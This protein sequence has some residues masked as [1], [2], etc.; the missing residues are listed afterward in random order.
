MP[1]P[2]P[3]ET[4]TDFMDRCVPMVMD[5]GS[6]DSEDQAVAM[7]SS[8]WEQDKAMTGRA[9]SILHIKS[10]NDEQRIIEGIASTPTPDRIGDIVDPLGA[11]FSLPMP[12]LWQHRSDQPIGQVTWAKAAA[13][14]I[15][16]KAKIAR[17]DEPGTLKDRLDE[18]WQSIK[19]G[20]V[21]AVS[22]GF[23][24]TKFD[25]IKGGGIEFKEWEWLELSAVTIPAN[26]DATIS[27][28]RSIDALLRQDFKGKPAA[29][30]TTLSDGNKQ[31]GGTAGQTKTVMAKEA[32]PMAKKTI[33]EQISA[34]EATRV[35]KAARMADIMETAGEKGETLGEP[36]REEYD[37]LKADVKSVD[38]HLVR[39]REMESI[40]KAAAKPVEGSSPTNALVTRGSGIISVKPNRPPGIG[41]ARAIIARMVAL[42]TQR[43]P[44][45]VAQERWPSD[46]EISDFLK[47]AVT[48]METVTNATE[49]NV[50]QNMPS[51]FVEYLRPMTLLGR[52]PGFRRVPFNITIPRQTGGVT[53]HWVAEGGAKPVGRPDFDSIT[54]RWNKCA[55]IVVF[56]QELARFS[57]PSVEALVRD[58]LARGI[59]QFLDEQFCN[60]SISEVSNTSPASITN[61]V[62]TAAASGDTISAV[63]ADVKAAFANFQAAE[64]SLDGCVWI[65]QSQQATG[66]SMML[67]PLGQPNYP[68][69]NATGGTWFGL[70]VF[71]STSVG[72]GIIILFKPPECLLADDGGV[73]IDVTTQASLVMDDNPTSAAQS[74][75]SLWQNN[76]IGVRAERFIN[77]K[78]RRADAVYYLTAADYGANGTA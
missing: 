36:E 51:E 75:V 27:V 74:L 68:G 41:M 59:A 1:T 40:N 73:N 16:F 11:K 43:D 39:L 50:S 55:T 32:K 28:V 70:P 6:A 61:G 24:A 72:S 26:V 56:S 10:F 78:M 14:G 53:G 63:T 65:M 21:R 17:S 67:N 23:N 45:L 7:C 76:Q 54:L 47:T 42:Q 3:G 29:T 5:D 8:M 49:L 66:L 25:F 9:Y 20:L 48:S 37:T 62:D 2:E 38:D 31:A 34:F 13:D 64:V 71:T 77:Y 46:P 35:A 4:E 22:I 57:N 69:I 15:P 33:A 12:L 60:P 52:I 18:A 19:L 58:D 44:V 30:G